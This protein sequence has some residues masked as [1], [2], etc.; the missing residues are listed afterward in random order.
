MEDT[1]LYRYVI[2]GGFMMIA[3]IPC[4]I[5]MVAFV[6]QGLLNLRRSRLAPPGLAKQLQEIQA[7]DGNAAVRERLASEDSSMGEILRNVMRHLQFKPDADPSDA[8]RTEIEGECDVLLQQ[9]SQLAVIYRI[10]PLFGLLGTVFG[11]IQ[12]FSDFTSSANPDLQQ[13]SNG[14][15]VAL[16]TTAWGLSIAIPSYIA[17]YL[18]QRRIATFE[19]I[20][21]PGEADRA[22]HAI[23]DLRHAA[24]A[25][26]PTPQESNSPPITGLE[27]SSQS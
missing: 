17:L 21:F 14:I 20:I 26:K 16:I 22:L 12:T 11:M 3:L 8:L 2:Q 1:L 24:K 13:L 4:M 5:L 18:F 7:K 27:S 23:V 9:N 25:A 6:I 19:H 15:N 10:S